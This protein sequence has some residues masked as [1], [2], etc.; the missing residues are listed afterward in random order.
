[1][2]A[3]D[4]LGKFLSDTKGFAILVGGLISWIT[5]LTGFLITVIYFGA[6][7][8]KNVMDKEYDNKTL[9]EAHESHVRLTQSTFDLRKVEVDQQLALGAARFGQID[10][11]LDA[12]HEKLDENNKVALACVNSIAL[13]EKGIGDLKTAF[14]EHEKSDHAFQTEEREER[15]KDRERLAKMEGSLGHIARGRGDRKSG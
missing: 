5:A 14:I 9:K 15:S 13:T 10:T 12:I 6:K 7:L 3:L 4:Q 1:M 2:D 11:K 8:Y